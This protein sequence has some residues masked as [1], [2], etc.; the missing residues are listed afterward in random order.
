MP[1][2]KFS[3]D[4]RPITDLK[5]HASEMVTKACAS[6]RPMLLTRRGRGVAVLLGLDAYE[7]LEARAA[8]IDAQQGRCG[9]VL[10][11]RD[12]TGLTTNYIRLEVP[13]VPEGA[14]V[15]VVIGPDTLAERG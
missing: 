12:G 6:R 7:Q 5:A 13:G 9:A 11:E 4:V 14:V 8:F 3:E 1:T 10:A 2:A 15:P